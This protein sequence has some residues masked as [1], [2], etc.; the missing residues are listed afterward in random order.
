MVENS[1]IIVGAFIGERYYGDVTR[2]EDKNRREL[3]KQLFSLV[4][5]DRAN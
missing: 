4:P 2:A 3:C 1:V 5:G